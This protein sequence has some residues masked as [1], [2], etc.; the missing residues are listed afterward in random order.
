V[1]LQHFLIGL[2]CFGLQVSNAEEATIEE[3]GI[4]IDAPCFDTNKLFSELKTKYK[5]TPIILG[6]ASD[7]IKSTM[8]FWINPIEETWTIIATKKDTSCVIGSGVN[9]KVVPSKKSTGV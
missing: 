1:K 2:A 9:F 6:I 8:S 5:E 3:D 4:T 7:Q